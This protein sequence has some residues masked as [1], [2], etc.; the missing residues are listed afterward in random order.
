MWDI[1]NRKKVKFN[2][3]NNIDE[4]H[5]VKESMYFTQQ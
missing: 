4:F 5:R 2:S 3:V 1:N